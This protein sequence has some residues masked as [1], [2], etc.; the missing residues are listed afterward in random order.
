MPNVFGDNGRLVIISG[1][2]RLSEKPSQLTGLNL[3]LSSGFLFDLAQRF[4]G[5]QGSRRD[6]RQRYALISDHE[7][8]NYRKTIKKM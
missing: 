2:S 7:T 5:L 3:V 6:P 4:V 8:A 1:T